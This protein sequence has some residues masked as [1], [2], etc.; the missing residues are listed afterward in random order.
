M[1]WHDSCLRF[2]VHSS[3]NIIPRSTPLEKVAELYEHEVDRGVLLLSTMIEPAIILLLGVG[4]GFIVV[5]MYLPIFSM[6]SVVG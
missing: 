1:T 4:I 2:T 5:A 3:L 6:A